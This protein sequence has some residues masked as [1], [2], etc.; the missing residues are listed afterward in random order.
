MMMILMPGG[1]V[2]VGFVGKDHIEVGLVVEGRIA[3]NLCPPYQL[4]HTWP[5]SAQHIQGPLVTLHDGILGHA[6][7]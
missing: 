6:T 1:L 2:E 7:P 4:C 3:K 5:S